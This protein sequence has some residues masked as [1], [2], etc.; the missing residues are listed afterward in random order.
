ML[1][2]GRRLGEEI[3][4]GDD[5]TITVVEVQGDKARLGIKAPRDIPVYRRELLDR[6][7]FDSRTAVRKYDDALDVATTALRRLAYLQHTGPI[8]HMAEPEAARV[9]REA[10]AKI[11]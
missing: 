2:L 4:I 1:V 6:A 7:D 8:E 3:V 10:L 11:G 9:A 5:I